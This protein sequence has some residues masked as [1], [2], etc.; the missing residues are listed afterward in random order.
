[1][2]DDG[3]PSLAD[4]SSTLEIGAKAGLLIGAIKGIRAVNK[5]KRMIIKS[6]M[7]RASED[8]PV[9]SAII[10]PN[11]KLVLNVAA[12]KTPGRIIVSYIKGTMRRAW[13]NNSLEKKAVHRPID[14]INGLLSDSAAL[15]VTAPALAWVFKSGVRHPGLAVVGGIAAGIAAR[16]IANKA[17]N[18]ATDKL[19]SAGYMP[20][21]LTKVDPNSSA[22][23]LMGNGSLLL[24]GLLGVASAVN[25]PVMATAP[26]IGKIGLGAAQARLGMDIGETIGTMGGYLYDR[27]KEL[28]QSRQLDNSSP[29]NTEPVV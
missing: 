7:K 12:G 10:D 27:G 21:I 2:Y 6:L 14:N 20:N 9:Y 22:Q 3:L 16:A 1:M 11:T 5:G 25:N 4:N 13:S 19:D 15:A 29:I 8:K 23:I 17:L 28:Y 18:A 26:L 24:G